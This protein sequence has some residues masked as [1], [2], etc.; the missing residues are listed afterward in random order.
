V[1]FGNGDFSL[2][3]VNLGGGLSSVDSVDATTDATVLGTTIGT[4]VVS[5][6]VSMLGCVISTVIVDDPE[7]E[8]E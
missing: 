1:G 8:V 2:V 7:I 6:R 5:V 3:I 4:T